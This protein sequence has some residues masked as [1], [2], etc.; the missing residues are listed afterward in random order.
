MNKHEAFHRKALALILQKGYRGTTMRDLADFM[1]CDVSN[2]YNYVAS[3]QALLKHHLFLMSQRFHQGIDEIAKSGLTPLAQ[4]EEVIRLYVS[5]SFEKPYQTALLVAEWRHLDEPDRTTFLAE[6]D[7]YEAK[8]RKMVKRGIRVGEL[9]TI[10][11]DT[12]THLIL[13]SLRWLFQYVKD[14]PKA[15]KIKVER[16]ITTFVLRGIAS[17]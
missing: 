8:V 11:P 4:I 9:K 1:Q 2:I 12:A 15:N 7:D 5:V 17:D 14:N 10:S 6:R 3:K 16:E 13:S